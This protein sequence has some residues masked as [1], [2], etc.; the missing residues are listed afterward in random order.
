MTKHHIRSWS[1]VVASLSILALLA[2]NLPIMPAHA[3]ALTTAYIRVSRQQ[4]SV[5]SGIS[6]TAFFKPASTATE[7]KFQ[8]IFPL[9]DNTVWCRTAGS[10]TFTTTALDGAVTPTASAGTCSQG[11]G[12]TT[13]DTFDFTTADLTPATLYGVVITGSAAVLGTGV[14]GAHVT[15]LKTRTSVPADIDTLNVALTINADDQVDVTATVDPT[16]TATVSPLS[17]VSLGTLTTTNVNQASL[18]D[19]V[20]TNAPNGYVS[21]VLYGATL[22]SGS[23]TIPDA[24][25]T[26]TAALSKFGASTDDTTSVDLATSQ[27]SCATGVGPYNATSLTTSPQV[28]GSRSAPGSTVDTLCFSASISATQAPG[29]YSST[30]TIVTTGKF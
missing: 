7:N 29:T 9:A 3:A 11:N 8:I 20:V 16:L 17:T 23:N 24:A 5:A 21:T 30:V 18:T 12:T 15:T 4:A 10:L 27:N 28:F 26:A 19:T 22:T 14:A 1:R 2:F 25:G 13:Y 6:L